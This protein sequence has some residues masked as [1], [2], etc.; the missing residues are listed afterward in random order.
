MGI[1]LSCL[2]ILFSSRQETAYGIGGVEILFPYV[3]MREMLT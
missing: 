2:Q 1:L 3:K